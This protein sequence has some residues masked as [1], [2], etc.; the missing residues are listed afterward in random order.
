MK[1]YNYTIPKVRLPDKWLFAFFSV[2][3]LLASQVQAYDVKVRFL[4]LANQSVPSLNVTAGGKTASFDG[5]YYT[6]SGLAEGSHELKLSSSGYKPFSASFSVGSNQ[7]LYNF[8]NRYA[9]KTTNGYVVEG[10]VIDEN[11]QKLSGV[12]V[13]AESKSVTTDT[14]GKF[15]L[16]FSEPKT[17]SV[18]FSKSGYLTV[19]QN[20]P[21]SDVA[22]RRYVGNVQVITGYAVQG[23]ILDIQKKG[24]A[25][26][27]VKVGD[28]SAVTD[29]SGRYKVSGL[30]TA[31]SYTLTATKNDMTISRSLTLN[32]NVPIFNMYALYLVDAYIIYGGVYD[33]QNKP[34]AGIRV[35][36]DG[37]YATTD[38]TGKYEFTTSKAGTHKIT[39]KQSG[40]K[41]TYSSGSVTDSYPQRQAN[42]LYAI[43][44]SDGYYIAGQVNLADK[45]VPMSKVSIKLLKSNGTETGVTATPN[46]DGSFWA[47]GLTE[48]GQYLA[49]ISVDVDGYREM[50]KSFNVYDSRP[51]AYSPLGTFNFSPNLNMGLAT[52]SVKFEQGGTMTYTV[53]IRNNGYAPAQKV[54]LNS[55]P[56]LPPGVTFISAKPI[57]PLL[58]NYNV[59][60]NGGVAN[61]CN[62]TD[63]TRV[64]ECKYL[65][66]LGAGKLTQMEVKVGFGLIKH[67]SGGSSS[68]EWWTT[69]TGGEG[70]VCGPGGYG[71]G[72]YSDYKE[73]WTRQP[74]SLSFFASGMVCK[75]CAV[76]DDNFTIQAPPAVKRTPVEQ[77]LSLNTSA[78][79]SRVEVGDKLNYTFTV[80]NSEKSPSAVKNTQLK[81]TLPNIVGVN[82]VDSTHGQCSSSGSSV[83]CNLDTLPNDTTAEIQLA[84]NANLVGQAKLSMVLTSEQA[85]KVEQDTG[86]FTIIPPPPPKPPMPVGDADLMLLIDDTGSMTEELTAVRNALVI[87]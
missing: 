69:C 85:P 8:G 53:N 86:N 63:E 5:T 29:S 67:T 48:Q 59:P 21:V 10:Y 84:L 45:T 78:S 81:I 9:I 77:F 36:L 43:S 3:F 75:D 46:T 65:G 66:T 22:P 33:V 68:W 31:G 62:I 38:S 61:N 76:N 27:T 80:R 51:Y 17:Y 54:K 74:F 16:Y 72:S 42:N 6:V 40:Y 73:W 49:E 19:T 32:T 25:G 70:V 13:S 83:T 39:V 4:D 47:K 52:D 18:S 1:W 37:Q 44:M 20:Y 30:Q 15:S 7:K 50:T 41:E 11:N 60:S 57:E 56:E 28:K 14:D 2:L 23:S 12:S 71:S 55:A 79:A 34:I 87:L 82:D 64:L 24:L 58:A 26:V 35:E